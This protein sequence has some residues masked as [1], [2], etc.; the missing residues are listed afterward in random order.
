[1]KYIMDSHGITLP[2]FLSNEKQINVLDIFDLSE[3]ISNVKNKRM[4]TCPICLNYCVA[5]SKINNCVH[6]YCNS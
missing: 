2:E 6:I 4:K 1:M 5:P 3:F